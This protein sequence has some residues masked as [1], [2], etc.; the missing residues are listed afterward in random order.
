MNFEQQHPAT[1]ILIAE[2]HP[3]P[4]RF[5]LALLDDP[6][7]KFRMIGNGDL[8][9]IDDD[10]FVAEDIMTEIIYVIDDDVIAEIAID[11]RAIVDANR[12]ADIMKG[13]EKWLE[14]ANADQTRETTSLDQGSVELSLHQYIL[15]IIRSIAV[16]LQLLHLY[17]AE[18]AIVFNIWM[19]LIAQ[20]EFILSL[21][22]ILV[23]H[24]TL[25][26]FRN[27]SFLDLIHNARCSCVYRY[28]VVYIRAGL[29]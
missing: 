26:E 14:A 21:R 6:I 8:I 5:L 9:H 13:E 27:G 22:N 4:N 11:N 15:P 17:T 20:I 12:K 2:F 16:A 24:E 28:R 29:E 23:V 10:D 19:L 18:R 7:S 25:P 3:D 1:R